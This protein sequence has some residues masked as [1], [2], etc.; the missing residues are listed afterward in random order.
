MRLAGFSPIV[1]LMLLWLPEVL[2]ANKTWG[3]SQGRADATENGPRLDSVNHAVAEDED[4][5]ITLGTNSA[6]T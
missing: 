4:K 5:Q 1:I 3:E 2:M 6:H